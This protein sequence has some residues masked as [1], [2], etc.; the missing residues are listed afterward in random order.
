MNLQYL[1]GLSLIF[2]QQSTEGEEYTDLTKTLT[3][4]YI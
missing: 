3:Y 4:M 2:G 1:Q